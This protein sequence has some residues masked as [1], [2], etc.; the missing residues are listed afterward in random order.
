M[1]QSS[2]LFSNSEGKN[3]V[4]LVLSHDSVSHRGPE[5]SGMYCMRLEWIEVGARIMEEVS[6][7]WSFSGKVAGLVTQS[8]VK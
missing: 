7:T 1:T 2:V 4:F 6:S 8:R 5:L 3:S